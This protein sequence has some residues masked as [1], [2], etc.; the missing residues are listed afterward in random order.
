MPASSR[1]APEADLDELREHEIRTFD[2]V[3]VNLYLFW[4]V[5]SSR[6]VREED[7]VEMI[8]I[9]GPALLRAAAKNFV[10]V[11]ERGR[12]PATRRSSPS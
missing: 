9:G 4:Y 5:T 11:A 10:D 1:A 2:L 12:R 3:C 8:D 7:A 6:N